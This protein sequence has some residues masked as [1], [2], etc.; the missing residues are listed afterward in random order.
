MKGMEP[1]GAERRR[2]KRYA[3]QIVVQWQRQLSPEALPTEEWR[4]AFIRD[5]SKGGLCFE[6]GEPVG[7]GDILYFKVKI[8]FAL[9]PF[10]CTGQVVRV[11][12]LSKPGN[13]E[14]GVMFLQIDPKDA[15]LIDLLAW[16]QEQKRQK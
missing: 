10:G 8:H 1:S 5:I 16:E 13:F 7:A 2:S 11:R 9:W 12:P 6:S 4:Y 14:I 15:D 3:E